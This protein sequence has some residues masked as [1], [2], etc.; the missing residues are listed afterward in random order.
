MSGRHRVLRN[1]RVVF[2]SKATGTAGHAECSRWIHEYSS[3]GYHIATTIQGYSVE[4]VPHKPVTL[5][6][7]VRE[8]TK[9]R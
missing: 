4:P 3:Y 1:G 2:T 8:Y 5:A 7:V 9:A 6:E